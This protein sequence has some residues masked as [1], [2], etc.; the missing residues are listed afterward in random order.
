MS[1]TEVMYQPYSPY[2]PYHQRAAA[3]AAA[4]CPGAGAASGI[5]AAQAA[6]LDYKRFVNPKMHDLLAGSASP[7]TPPSSLQSLGPPRSASSTGSSSS[8]HHSR[9]HHHNHHGGSGGTTANNSV[10]S[11]GSSSGPHGTSGRPSSSSSTCAVVASSSSP[12]TPLAARSPDREESSV[13][14]SKATTSSSSLP[15]GH[16]AVVTGGGGSPPSSAVTGGTSAAPGDAHYVSDNCV[17]FTYYSGDISSVVDEHFSRALSESGAYDGTAGSSC[18]SGASQ[19]KDAPPMAQ[20]NFPASFWNCHQS[21]TGGSSSHGMSTATGSAGGSV[22]S[23]VDL[24]AS[25]EPHPYHHAHHHA[26]SAA[27]AAAIH[28]SLQ[29]DPWHYALTAPQAGPYRSSA[30]HELAYSAGGA[31]HRFGAQQY[32]SLL[33]QPRSSRLAPATCTALDKSDAWASPAARYHHDQLTGH[34]VV[35]A[36]GYQAAAH[37]HYGMGAAAAAAAMTDPNSGG[38]MLELY[39]FQAMHAYR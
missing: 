6:C 21:P 10:N 7:A 8:S 18:K 37:H 29:S 16:A 28:A 15:G 4:S 17:V 12:S 30:M 35:D 9:S 5:A 23:P 24:Y 34:H 19:L 13:H 33:L 27:N 3:A 31:A 26:A 14:A 11:G 38:Y 25:S 22:S 1:C 39:K 2:F 32:G 20:R 36:S